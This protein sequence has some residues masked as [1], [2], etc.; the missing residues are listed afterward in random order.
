LAGIPRFMFGSAARDA[1][2]WIVA[3]LSWD[4]VGRMRHEMMLCY[5]AGYVRGSRGSD[6]EIPGRSNPFP[7]LSEPRNP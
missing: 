4:A 7:S 1:M 5:F 3:L 2:R 6:G